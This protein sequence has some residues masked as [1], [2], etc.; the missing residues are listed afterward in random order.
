M[1]RI[2]IIG[3]G[4]YQQPLIVKARETGFETHVFAW[5]TG[6]VAGAEGADHFYPISSEQK[7]E[8]LEK[9]RQL[10]VAA[11]VSVG[12]DIAA[13]TA[14]YV[15]EKLHLTSNAYA[16][17]VCTTNKLISRS[18]FEKT[19]VRQPAYA[20]VGAVIPLEQIEKLRYPLIVK[21]SDRS[22]GRGVMKV[23]DQSQ[24]FRAINA[25]REISFER[26]AIVEE[27]IDGRLYSCE[28]I[29][30]DG[31][32]TVLGFTGRSVMEVGGRIC[33]TAY[34]QPALLPLRAMEEMRALSA[35]VLSTLG[36]RN[37]ASSIEF[38]LDAQ[39]NISI[40]EV[41]PSMYGDFI[42]THLICD[43]TGC[44][45][46]K[47][48]IDIACG[49]PPVIPPARVLCREEVRFIYSRPQAMEIGCA[50]D[51]VE[52][53]LSPD[54]HLPALPDGHRYGYCILRHDIRAYGGCRSWELPDGSFTPPPLA[55]LTP[56]HYDALDSEYTAFWYALQQMDVRRIHMP[57]YLPQAWHKIARDAGYDVSLYRLGPDLKPLELH[58][59]DNEA[60]LLC[61][62]HGQCE[63]FIRRYA[64]DH[65]HV[66]IDHSMAFFAKPVLKD[67]VY[68]L[69]ACRKFFA[70]PD[71]GY[72]VSQ[73][74]AKIPLERDISSRRARALLTALELGENAAYKEQQSGE[75][76]LLENRR[77]MSLLT[78]RMLAAIDYG[79]ALRRR[80]EN[81][82]ALHRKFSPFQQFP[83]GPEVT[84]VPQ[85]YP[86][87]VS[88]DVRGLLISQKIY[89]PLMWR[90]LMDAR[91]K[92][93]VEQRLA[94]YL[95]CLPIDPVYSIRDMEYIGDTVSALL[96]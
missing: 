77:A 22:G 88:E 68:N 47:M 11:V 28:C 83:L 40:I 59:Q 84:A 73:S 9:C 3:A 79:T 32:H 7:D 20:E 72:I 2:A 64:F 62:H 17:V 21:P 8:I 14:A 75:Q 31:E 13:L 39:G 96:S 63:D 5:Q 30:F 86:L 61:N 76:E 90:R 70:V 65:T 56:A 82:A 38:I 71:G 69:Y 91:H 35:Q 93:T 52:C 27:F 12:S 81:F 80:R 24:L 26:K 43:V 66:I 6:S 95:L 78:Q 34:E 19:G 36:L 49:L 46:L 67:G 50:P 37:G 15:C 10:Q 58:Q 41:T 85:F 55:G 45:Y 57:H 94:Q 25:A 18:L 60:V 89:V 54:S 33:E 23:R 44:D 53:E 87:L 16:S 74:L 51:V 4:A 42:G 1:K 48:V 29:S 92:N